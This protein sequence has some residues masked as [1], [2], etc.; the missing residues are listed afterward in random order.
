MKYYWNNTNDLYLDGEI[1][2]DITGYEGRYQISN[3]GRVKSL[4]RKS[5]M[6]SRHQCDMI[7]KSYVGTNGYLITQLTLGKSRH[8]IR[9]HRL[10][11][12][13]FIPNELGLKEVNHIDEDKLNNCVSNLE[14]CDRKYNVNYG[15]RNQKQ[16]ETSGTPVV[17]I[18]VSNGNKKSFY[19]IRDCAK[20][21]NRNH[22]NVC[23][24]LNGTQKT[25]NGY[26]IEFLDNNK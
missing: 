12:T 17:A 3:L 11:A 24:C 5:I 20:F 15:S 21:L 4:K 23:A 18:N 9:V 13:E 22:A 26:R 8:T 14:W 6:N 25:C 1:W 19:S 7:L 2:K 16:S 10:V